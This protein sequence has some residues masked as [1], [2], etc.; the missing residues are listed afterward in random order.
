MYNTKC[1]IIFFISFTRCLIKG[2]KFSD[3]V[4]KIVNRPLESLFLDADTYGFCL[5]DKYR[6]AGL[7]LNVQLITYKMTF[8][9]NKFNPIV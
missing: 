6:T 4:Q 7:H 1:I 2:L 5:F 9:W 3:I 8:L